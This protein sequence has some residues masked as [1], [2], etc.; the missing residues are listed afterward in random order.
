MVA[1]QFVRKVFLLCTLA[2]ALAGGA[3]RAAVLVTWSQDG[4]DVVAAYNGT[5]GIDQTT[6]TDGGGHEVSSTV[7]Y[8]WMEAGVPGMTFNLDGNIS[9]LVSTQA[10]SYSGDIFAA[11]YAGSS[12]SGYVVGPYGF[13]ADTQVS[14]TLRFANTTLAAMGAIFPTDFVFVKKSDNTPLVVYSNV[15]E[16]STWALLGLGL[17]TALFLRRRLARR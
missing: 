3:A 1:P 8:N 6:G 5:M 17:G 14:G 12:G 16:P 2:V 13:T 7:F 4:T 15:P 10:S 11:F 9:T